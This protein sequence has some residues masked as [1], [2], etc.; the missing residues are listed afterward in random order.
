M[1]IQEKTENMDFNKGTG[2]GDLL[3]NERERKGLSQ[4]QVAGITRLRKH[5][6]DALE[7]ENWE[8]L[9]SPVFVKGFLR[10]YAQAIG[11]DGK[12][13]V[14]IYKRIATVKEQI[15]KP[16]SEPKGSK[17]R[18]IYFLSCIVAIIAVFIYMYIGYDSRQPA[19]GSAPPVP[20]SKKIEKVETQ[21]KTG[22]SPEAIIMVEDEEKIENEAK[23]ATQE[24]GPEE[25][26]T[27]EEEVVRRPDQEP[28]REPEVISEPERASVENDIT[29][30]PVEEEAT[31]HQ[32][33]GGPV[34]HDLV[35]TGI[36][37]MRTYVK[38]YVDDNSPKE[39][40][41]RPGSRPQWTAKKGFNI[42]LGNAAGM[43]FDLNGKRMKDFGKLGKVVR[44]SFPEDFRPNVYGD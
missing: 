19:D 27:R 3:R 28:D 10:S 40:V 20:P 37:N 18:V 29:L 24:E 21:E 8:K 39:Y 32:S 2:L 30:P 22:T 12:E 25:V 16:L 41:F 33:E 43:E 6:I 15:P 26:V 31:D 13:A 38:I 1:D 36:V 17:K 14:G 44:L 34:N 9:P 35:L 42:I 7:N 11:F 4:D 5:F 23:A